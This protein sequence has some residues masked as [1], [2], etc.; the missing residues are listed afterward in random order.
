MSVLKIVWI[1][2]IV[3]SEVGEVSTL[4]KFCGTHIRNPAMR[5]PVLERKTGSCKE[6][7]VDVDGAEK[8]TSCLNWGYALSAMSANLHGARF[9]R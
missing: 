5:L 9:H 2:E 4:A 8:G 1:C 6:E 7:R 3:W